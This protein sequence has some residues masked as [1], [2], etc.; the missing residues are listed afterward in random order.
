MAVHL[1][2]RCDDEK[3]Y[4]G[5]IRDAWPSPKLL[6]SFDRRLVTCKNCIKKAEQQGEWAKLDEWLA[7]MAANDYQ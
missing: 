1:R 5:R 7:S 2:S 6:V 3:T 4:C